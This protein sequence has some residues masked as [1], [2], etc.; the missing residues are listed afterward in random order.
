MAQHARW[1]HACAEV[2]INNGYSEEDAYRL[3]AMVFETCGRDFSKNPII[4]AEDEIFIRQHDELEVENV[5]MEPAFIQELEADNTTKKEWSVEAVM[6]AT[7]GSQA[8]AVCDLFLLYA[9]ELKIFSENSGNLGLEVNQNVVTE[10]LLVT[11]KVGIDLS[12]ATENIVN[13]IL[14]MRWIERC[15]DTLI[16]Q[17]CD[18]KTSFNFAEALHDDYKLDDPVDIAEEEMSCWGD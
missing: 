15:A 17:G 2:F 4:L 10:S 9:S 14:K 3:S 16:K 1:Q 8:D 11:T 5:L 7:G 6:A 12:E 13:R 18:E